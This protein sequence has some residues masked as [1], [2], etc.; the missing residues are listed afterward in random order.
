M[1]VYDNS[2]S[3]I[4]PEQWKNI[5][6]CIKDAFTK[7]IATTNKGLLKVDNVAMDYFNNK[8]RNNYT[9]QMMEQESTQI[10]SNVEFTIEHFKTNIGEFKQYIQDSEVLVKSLKT[11]LDLFQDPI[12]FKKWILSKVQDCSNKSKYLCEAMIDE[13]KKATTQTFEYVKSSHLEFKNLVGE[14]KK[15]KSLGDYIQSVDRALKQAQVDMDSKQIQRFA[16][17]KKEMEQLMDDKI[18]K[19]HHRMEMIIQQN[20]DRYNEMMEFKADSIETNKNFKNNL[21]EISKTHAEDLDCIYNKFNEFEADSDKKHKEL[22]KKH[23]DLSN[24]FHNDRYES[25][26]ERQST[27]Q[28][29]KDVRKELIELI[30]DKN[31]HLQDRIKSLYVVTCTCRTYQKLEA[32]KSPKKTG[33]YSDSMKKVREYITKFVLKREIHKTLVNETLKGT[34]LEA[35]L[36]PKNSKS[37]NILDELNSL[38]TKVNLIENRMRTLNSV[39]LSPE[40]K[41]RNQK[42]DLSTFRSHKGFIAR[43]QTM[44][45]NNSTRNMNLA[46]STTQ[47]LDLPRVQPDTYREGG[48]DSTRMKNRHSSRRSSR[49]SSRQSSRGPSQGQ[50]PSMF[51]KYLATNPQK[52]RLRN[53]TVTKGPRAL[54][55]NNVISLS[56]TKKESSGRDFEVDFTK[57]SF[58]K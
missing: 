25:L 48:Y 50:S 3:Q 12:E 53:R 10:Q 15:F 26:K 29:I 17:M 34:S 38:K 57:L 1:P 14:T 13:L 42:Q 19:C 11:K 47:N 27:T 6:K 2:L 54:G 51:D 32:A 31:H 56:M 7:I 55:A 41:S 21:K 49:Q 30:E 44:R 4:K 22:F 40:V 35:F 52:K 16:V 33:N 45:L 37:K 23:M 20:R 18:S 39:K 24:Y 28:R 9:I 58:D 46:S 43:K 5:P 36:G 8:N